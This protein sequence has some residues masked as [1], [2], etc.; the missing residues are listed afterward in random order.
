MQQSA[1]QKNARTNMA[2]AFSKRNRQTDAA[3]TEYFDIMPRSYHI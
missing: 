2:R 3:H 1:E